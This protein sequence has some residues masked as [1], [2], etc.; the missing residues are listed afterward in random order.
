MATICPF[1]AYATIYQ[2]GTNPGNGRPPSWTKYA[3]DERS[4]DSMNHSNVYTYGSKTTIPCNAVYVSYNTNA[5]NS[6]A[7]HGLS[8]NRVSNQTMNQVMFTT[9]IPHTASGAAITLQYQAGGDDEY[10]CTTTDIVYVQP[11]ITD[12]TWYT[13]KAATCTEDG[14]KYQICSSCGK[15]ANKTIIPKLGHAYD[16]VWQQS[17]T[18]HWRSCSRCGNKSNLSN[19]TFDD[20]YG[21]TATCTA[22]GTRY[23]KCE[24][25]GYVETSIAPKLG[26]V[27]PSSYDFTTKPGY[28]IKKCTR[29]G[30]TLEEIAVTYN[31]VFDGNG[32]TSGSMATQT[33]QLNASEKL[34]INQY[35]RDKFVFIGWSTE[36]NPTSN[37]YADGYTVRNLVE[38]GKTITLYAQW[39]HA[40]TVMVRYENPDGT[41]SEYETETQYSDEGDQFDWVCKKAKNNPIQWQPVDEI[42]ETVGEDNKTWKIDVKLQE[43]YV[44]IMASLNGT[45]F[46]DLQNIGTTDLYINGKSVGRGIDDYWGI[47]KYGSTY[48]I[49]NVNSD[50]KYIFV[51][52]DGGTS[53]GTMKKVYTDSKGHTVF[54]LT[55][56]FMTKD[57]EATLKSGQEVNDIFKQLAGDL[58]YIKHI[59]QAPEVVETASSVSIA[60][61]GT[62][63]AWF[64]GESIFICTTANHVKFASDSSN[65]LAN[66]PNLEDIGPLAK[67]DTSNVTSLNGFFK[68]DAKLTTLDLTTWITKRVSN[69]SDFCNGCSG[70]TEIYVDN[71]NWSMENVGDTNKGSNLF[72]GCTK[73][74]NYSAD[75]KQNLAQATTSEY[76]TEREAKV[77]WNHPLKL[78]QDMVNNRASTLLINTYVREGYQF[79]GWSKEASPTDGTEQYADAAEVT[80]LTFDTDGIAQLFAVWVSNIYSIVFDKN[81]A[82][83]TGEMSSQTFRFDEAKALNPIVYV[84]TGYHLKHWTSNADGTGDKYLDQQ[85]VSNLKAINK[86][87]FK[88]YAQW[89]PNDYTVHFNSNWSKATGNM[90]DQS[91]TYDKAQKL[92]ANGFRRAGYTSSGWNTKPDLSGTHYGER[93]EVINLTDE[94]DGVVDLYAEWTANHYT[95]KF[96][97]NLQDSVPIEGSMSDIACEYD[98][99]YSLP[100][101]TYTK[102]GNTFLGWNTAPD[103]SG[104]EYKDM[105]TIRNL[106]TIKDGTV[107]LYAQW[108]AATYIIQYS[109]NGNTSGTMPTQTMSYGKAM[110]LAENKFERVG[111]TFKYWHMTLNN[112][113]SIYE[114]KALV[115]NL[116][117]EN[118]RVLTFTAQWTPNAYTVVFDKNATKAVGTMETQAFTYDK[119]QKL[120]KNAYTYTGYV[121]S[122]WNTKAD[123][124]GTTYDDE[125]K[126]FNLISDVGGVMTL[127]AQW[128]PI[129]YNIAF[130]TNTGTGSMTKITATYDQELTLPENLFKKTGYPFAGWNT[131]SDGSGHSYLDKATVVNL[132]DIQDTTIT[133]YAQWSASVYYIKYHGGEGT[134]GSM[135]D[136]PL[137][138]DVQQQLNPNTFS[139]EGYSFVHWSLTEDGTGTTFND[140]DAVLNL[141]DE[142]D[143]IIHMYAQWI[144]NTYKV[145]FKSN[146]PDATGSMQNQVHTFDQSQKLTKNVYHKTGYTF[147]GWNTQSDGNGTSYAD[148]LE[149][150]NL[151]SE[152]NGTVILYAQWKA[153]AY[154]VDFKQNGENVI[155]T[156]NPQPFTYDQAQPL[157][158]NTYRKT[159]YL[160]DYWSTSKDGTGTN[161]TDRQNVKNLTSDPYGIVEL[162]AQWTP[163][164]YHV[165]FEAN[166][167]FAAGSMDI[168]DF[169]YDIPQ[170]LLENKYTYSG[171]LFNGWNTEAD[172]SGTA[173]HDEQEVQNLMST[174]GSTITLYAQWQANAYYV[175]FDGNGAD[176]GSMGKQA[177]VYDK[178]MA[179]APNGFKKHG[180]HFTHWT[181]HADG[182]GTILEDEEVV[183]NL[184]D[185]EGGTAIL[186]A[187]WEPNEYTVVYNKNATNATGT[188]ASST[189]TYNHKGNLS[190]NQYSRIGYT[191][192][193][194]NS[195]KDGSG[196]SYADGTEVENLTNDNNGT[197]TLYAQWKAITYKVAYDRNNENAKGSIPDAKA[198][199]DEAFIIGKCAYT[200]EGYTFT[201][202]NTKPDGTGASYPVGMEVINLCERNND[203]ITLYAQ[204]TP[205]TYSIVYNKNNS[206]AS[207]AMASQIFRFDTAMKL[208]KNTFTYTGYLFNG[209]NTE[210]DGTGTAYVDEQEVSNLTSADKGTIILYAQWKPITY[211]VQFHNGATDAHGTMEPQTFVY[212]Q[213]ATLLSNAFTKTGYQ[214]SGWAT[215]AGSDIVAYQN[216][217]SVKNLVSTDKAVV[218]LYAVWG[219]ITYYIVF[220]GNEST[221]GAMDT[222]TMH[223]DVAQKLPKGTFARYGYQF[224]GWNTR[225]DGTGAGYSDES[226]VLN[227]TTNENETVTLYAQWK[228]NHYTIHFDPNAND[229]SGIMDNQDVAFGNETALKA[230]SFERSGYIFA[231][232]NLRANGTGNAY[233]DQQPVL[234]LVMVDG[235]TITLYAQWT[236]ITYTVTFDPGAFNTTGSM[237]VQTFTYGQESPLNTN[238]YGRS[239]YV[240]EG[241]GTEELGD[242]VVYHNNEVVL[243]LANTQDANVTL[244]AK[245]GHSTYYV[246]FH[247]NGHTSG[248]MSNQEFVYGEAQNLTK[249]GFIKS[250]WTF[251]GWN[252]KDDGSGEAYADEESLSNPIVEAGGT[253]D[254]YAQWEVQSSTITYELNGGEWASGYTAP[255]S[256]LYNEEV[257]LPTS[258]NIRRNGFIFLGWYENSG[259]S[260]TCY[261]NLPANTGDKILYA[262]WYDMSGKKNGISKPVKNEFQYGN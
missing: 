261:T 26:H 85:I 48:E 129:T 192:V 131:N 166:A 260:G 99:D 212:D 168:Q 43:I 128:T 2:P 23:R 198:T 210:A 71:N 149:V 53:T 93:E 97:K 20:Y 187:Q 113:T 158:A 76:L 50:S 133:L 151:T 18:Q 262:A 126:V 164:V 55:L 220:D 118:G 54:G 206:K 90:K 169:T 237:E 140:R 148:G 7:D 195:K 173:Y 163:I 107:T 73:L 96:D 205:N 162:Y 135:S 14:Y 127:Y 125:A 80:N 12:S 95:I 228:A 101:N 214:F 60:S 132:A 87:T 156:M 4:E 78:M 185:E 41:F 200:L 24:T 79:D 218:D 239:G 236:P 1:Y 223:Y 45:K 86:D 154:T 183:V 56:I 252:T 186:Y 32:A 124:S 58:A 136:Q 174:N 230:N 112:K 257:V 120:K 5:R 121:F 92:T 6:W 216:G 35:T 122:G 171:Y 211:T 106:T 37:L 178:G 196:T 44:D 115:Q 15:E 153:N 130:D 150:M 40:Y 242:I 227:L 213:A 22:A 193:G 74:P 191:F 177:L 82:K 165:R 172:G 204:W 19:H 243:N 189:F 145:V 241:W 77:D 69:I 259:F 201:E 70:L 102:T 208:S 61:E 231:G 175:D 114:D 33:I 119:T 157:R 229:T 13:G 235:G 38:A 57:E 250:G 46:A 30:Q 152:Q 225:I 65:L 51:G 161:F 10:M 31:I 248:A 240:F 167:D 81:D 254:L 232:W 245:W 256:H 39:A 224:V 247:G 194:W 253:I 16:S 49:K 17:T 203:K 8:V 59:H 190:N 100:A 217:E 83:A 251:T 222:I 75:K 234:N 88:L 170:T 123:G 219:S 64:S 72:A 104:D 117:T 52:I 180:Y 215:T 3:I 258:V 144:A 249:N 138:Y 244:Y 233:M 84:K 67:W 68:N 110:N 209:W 199:Y 34:L 21:S 255:T 111:Y 142:N 28:K 139:K 246:S 137:T 29:C 147:T 160:F 66:M 207:G 9:T 202:W 141:T 89:Q 146:D 25:C 176:A 221:S 179:L 155:G 116:T 27:S 134:T 143:A 197:V 182:T 238:Q 159:G 11:V 94:R 98:V 181:L 188:M 91:F 105:V 103:G 47:V 62:I 108:K 36:K 109:G 226:E 184:T 42:H 63:Q